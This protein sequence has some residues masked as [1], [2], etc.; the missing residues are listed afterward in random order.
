MEQEIRKRLARAVLSVI[1]NLT[2]LITQHRAESRRIRLPFRRRQEVRLRIRPGHSGLPCRFPAT[3]S[4]LPGRRTQVYDRTRFFGVGEAQKNFF[5]E[6][7]LPAGKGRGD[8]SRSRVGVPGSANSAPPARC[9][10]NG[11][12]SAAL[13]GSLGVGKVGGVECGGSRFSSTGSRRLRDG[14]PRHSCQRF[15]R[16]SAVADNRR[17]TAFEG[18]VCRRRRRLRG[19]REEFRQRRDDRL[20]SRRFGAAPGAVNTVSITTTARAESV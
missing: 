5:P 3:P 13:P 6:F 9:A 11:W 17:Q 2:M 8:I 20:V 7:S 12:Q 10:R 16:A 1:T 4:I 14:G 19:P 15:F 18:R